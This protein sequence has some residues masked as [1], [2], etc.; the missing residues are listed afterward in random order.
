MLLVVKVVMG[1]YR[2]MKGMAM[3]S[4]PLQLSQYDNNASIKVFKS[5]TSYTKTEHIKEQNPNKSASITITNAER[6]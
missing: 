2:G 4:D 6:S 5:N 3:I 1:W